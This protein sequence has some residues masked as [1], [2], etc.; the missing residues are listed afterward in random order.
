MIARSDVIAFIGTAD[1]DR[2]CAFYR[3]VLGL[4]LVERNEFASVFDANGTMLRVTTVKEVAPRPYT[5][6]GWGVDDLEAALAELDV[7]PLRYEGM[8][9]DERG[10]WTA[11]F[12][13]RV[14]WFRDPD[15]NVLSLS[16]HS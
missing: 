12:G 11:P 10:I 4:R 3:D 16:Q 14:A 15:G 2:A 6:L 5:V 9:Q 13:V 7:E 8:G 1:P